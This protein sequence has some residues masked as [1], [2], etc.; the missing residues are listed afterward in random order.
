MRII[1]LAFLVF[2]STLSYTYER[3]LVVVI[4]SY[5]NAEW[6]QR[7]LDS[8][9]MQQYQNYRVIYID[10]CSPDGTGNL[11]EK[12]VKDQEQENRVTIIHN[13]KRRGALANHY[14]AIHM[15]ENHEIV[16]C[17]DGDDWLKHKHVFERVNYAYKDPNVW[18]TYGQYEIYPTSELGH[19]R[20]LPESII[21]H[22]AYR[23]CMWV[24]SALRTFYAGLFKQIKLQDL[25]LDGNFF[26]ASGDLAFMYPMLEMANGKF[27]FIDDILYVYNCVTP[28]NDFKVRVL[29]QIFSS[30]VIRAR[31]KYKAINSF[32]DND[33]SNNTVDLVIFSQDNPVQLC[34]LLESVQQNVFGIDHIHVLYEAKEK[35][36]IDGYQQ[37]KKLFPSTIFNKLHNDFKHQII[38]IFNNDISSYVIFACDSM[39]CKDKIDIKRCINLLNQTKAYGFFLSLGKNISWNKSLLRSQQ[40]PKFIEIE[41]DILAWQ[42]SDSEVDW[43]DFHNVYMTIYRK[44]DMRKKFIDIDFNSFEQLV[45]Y[46]QKIP[47]QSESV[48]LC[49]ETSKV[50]FVD[51]KKGIM[52]YVMP[53]LLQQL[54][55]NKQLDSTQFKG[56]HNKSIY[57]E[58]KRSFF[59]SLIK[60]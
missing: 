31:K 48:A 3:P 49:F 41:N 11:V 34:M 54:N 12:Y 10:D 30:N 13:T 38:D 58:P 1:V 32:Y 14:R 16:L 21:S 33:N 46:W 35:Q 6:Y 28:Y 37:C 40:Q 9:F 56:V 2:S 4:P 18:L 23:E 44:K 29:V 19:C 20:K 47:I 59:Y 27:R 39:F 24:T 15:C 43:H 60:S 36:F 45:A 26:Q 51:T 55:E 53:R 25:L 57:F 50:L 17:L 7:N 5:H 8:V 52:K 22:H 42:Y